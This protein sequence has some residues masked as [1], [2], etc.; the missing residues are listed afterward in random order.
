M[1]PVHTDQLCIGQ[2][3]NRPQRQLPVFQ[4]NCW[5]HTEVIGMFALGVFER[6]LRIGH[7]RLDLLPR[8][9]ADHFR[10][11][12]GNL[13]GKVGQ[14]RGQ[15][16]LV[17]REDCRFQERTLRYVDDTNGR[18]IVRVIVHLDPIT[19]LRATTSRGRCLIACTPWID[20]KNFTTQRQPGKNGYEKKQERSSSPSF[21]LNAW[22][23]DPPH[24]LTAQHPAHQYSM[25]H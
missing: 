25:Q 12:D 13:E 22:F 2:I 5:R 7:H 4:N 1:Y 24:A 11:I 20:S 14:F 23:T 9:G 19:G 10:R 15:F 16:R 21:F 17:I 6:S 18:Q 3:Y 8:Q